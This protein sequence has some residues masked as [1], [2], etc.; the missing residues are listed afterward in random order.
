MLKRIFFLLTFFA[1]QAFSAVFSHED[2][3]LLQKHFFA[4]IHPNGAIVASPSQHEPNYYYDWVRDS[5][6]AMGLV[7]TWFEST[8]AIKYKKRLLNY[9]SWTEIIQHQHDTLPGQDILGEPKFYIDG[10]PFDGP[11]G[12]PQNDGPALRASVLTRFAQ[13]LLDNNETD[14]VQ[15]HLYNKSMNPQNM[16]TI[17]MDLEYTAHHWQDAN[18]DLWEEVLGDH[19]FTAMA[20]KNALI[21]GAELAHRLNDEEAATYYEIQ[22]NLID[23]RLKKHLDHKNK[24]IQAT[25]PPH[26]GPQKTQELDSSIIL[27]ILLN[28]KH[29]GVFSPHNTYVKNTVNALHEQFNLMFPINKNHSGAILFG[30]YPGDTYDGYVTDSEGNPWFILTAT[31]A[32]YYY[33]LADSLSITQTNKPLIIKYLNTGDNYLKLIKKYAPEMKLSEQINLEDGAQQG[34]VSLTWSYV[35]LLRALDLREK[36]EQKIKA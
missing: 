17:K 19:F 11:W 27:G 12:R 29:E 32:E 8:K 4:N 33:T 23:N 26:S 35:S 30:R 2:I 28:P 13:Q 25:L 20:Q 36:I 1:S 21:D 22:A 6:I 5:A 24:L 15:T 10:Y 14:Y 34:A 16:G 9:V 7:E 31:I 18:F 3:K